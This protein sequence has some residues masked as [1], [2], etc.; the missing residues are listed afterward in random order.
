MLQ[1]LKEQFRPEPPVRHET[2]SHHATDS[3]KP[4]VQPS[5]IGATVQIKGEIHASEPLYIDG[6]IEGRLDCSGQRVTIGK[7]GTAVTNIQAD[8]IVVMGTVRGDVVCTDFAEVRADATLIGDIFARRIRV[9][10]GAVLKGRVE[11]R[12][13]PQ[14]NARSVPDV[15]AKPSAVPK[16]TEV[17]VANLEIQQAGD[18]GG[19]KSVSGSSVLLI[20]SR[21]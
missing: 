19:V 6:K 20:P 2:P 3:V 17:P 8:Q 12:T 5:T 21:Q 1:S 16:P 18:N 7:K 10:E 4:P 13:Q 15:S 9:E 11:I 14:E